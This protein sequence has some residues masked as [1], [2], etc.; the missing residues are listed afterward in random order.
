M[1]RRKGRM[2]MKLREKLLRLSRERRRRGR[3]GLRLIVR[4]MRIRWVNGTP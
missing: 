3:R 4:R 1:M 2:R